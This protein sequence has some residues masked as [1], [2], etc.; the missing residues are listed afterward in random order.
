MALVVAAVFVTAWV[1]LAVDVVLVIVWE[2]SSQLVS[3]ERELSL[4]LLVVG[5]GVVVRVVWAS[6][7]GK[8]YNN[9]NSGEIGAE[10]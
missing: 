5:K 2:T 8:H 4:I 1:G 9:N 10:S 6:V 7:E 3:L